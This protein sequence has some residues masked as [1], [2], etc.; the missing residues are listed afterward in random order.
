VAIRL[1]KV[2]ED[3]AVF[4]DEQAHIEK[5]SNAETLLDH[6]LH[7]YRDGVRFKEEMRQRRI[8]N[9]AEQPR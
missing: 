3:L 4:L 1:M 8:K 9:G 7:E 2:N 6:L 5:R